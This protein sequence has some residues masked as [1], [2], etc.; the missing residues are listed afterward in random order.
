MQANAISDLA[1]NLIAS[2]IAFA[3]GSFVTM[4]W[5]R[6]RQRKFWALTDTSVPVIMVT[7]TWG[8]PLT[9]HGNQYMITTAADAISVGYV[10]SSIR[11]AYGVKTQINVRPSKQFMSTHWNS[12][13]VLVGGRVRNEATAALLELLNRKWVFPYEIRDQD[14]SQAR[15]IFDV[16]EQ[17]QYTAQQNGAA[18]EQDWG[19]IYRI[20]N[21][22]VSDGR[23]VFLFYGLHPFGTLAAAK[24]LLPQFQKELVQELSK[25]RDPHAPW[26]QIL[27]SAK[28]V[29]EDVFPKIHDVRTVRER[30]EQRVP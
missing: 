30:K 3:F 25:R 26:Y 2:A 27:V 17:H 13:L 16:E 19:I 4:L 8:D 5:Q 6:G 11:Q 7:G 20:P 15:C 14:E 24:I 29:D 22:M 28:I 23:P 9:E 21:P 12:I 1:L 10:Y 18:I